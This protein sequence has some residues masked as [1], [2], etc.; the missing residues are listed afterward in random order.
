[1]NIKDINRKHF[2]KTDMF[3]RVDRG[4]SSRLMRFE[5]GIIYVELEV[6]EKWERS[7]DA[8]AWA[9]A[10]SWRKE[11]PEFKDAVAS[12][13]YVIDS[14]SYEYKRTLL[15][16]GVKPGYDAHKGVFFK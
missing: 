15:H 8:A 14:R 11:N 5:H 6:R 4:L 12:K 7:L 2:I 9:I 1:M 16:L 13:V 10:H 3:F